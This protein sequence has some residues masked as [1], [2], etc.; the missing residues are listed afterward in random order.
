MLADPQSKIITDFGILNDTIAKDDWH[1]G[2][3]NPG[4]YRV[5]PDGVVQ[6]KYFAQD[7]TERYFTPTILL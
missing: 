2:M 7:F 5:N 6:S 4:T 1:Y 3:T